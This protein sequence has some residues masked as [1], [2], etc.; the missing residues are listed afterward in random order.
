MLYAA[1]VPRPPF[2]TLG[3]LGS[4]LGCTAMA[5]SLP[6]TTAGLLGAIGVTGSGLLAQTLAPVAEPLFIGSAVLL[7]VGGLACSRLV[8]L[9]VGSA[10]G[11]LYILMFVLPAGAGGAMTAMTSSHAHA[12]R[13]D[14]TSFYTGAGLLLAAVTLNAWRRRRKSCHPILRL[15]PNT[16]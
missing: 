15:R 16:L 6:A 9:L 11:L 8:A 12:S 2:T 14:P 7:A 10:G 3:V 13:A 4:V 1:R 5:A